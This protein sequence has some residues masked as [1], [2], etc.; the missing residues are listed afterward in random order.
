M[1]DAPGKAKSAPSASLA[2]RAQYA[3]LRGVVGALGAMPWGS[4]VRIGEGL[5]TLGYRPLGVR[6]RV[7][8]KQVAAAFPG[9]P[10]REVLRI[11]RAAFA[12]LGRSTIEAAMLGSLGRDAVLDLFEGE[13]GWG[14]VTDGMAQGKG[15]IF[16]TGHIGN[17]ELG[18]SYIAARGIPLDVIARRMAN[19]MFD[20]YLTSTR[21]RIGMH[22]VY[23]ADAV[24]R[25][26]R[27][28]REGRAVAFVADQGVLGLAST[29]VPFFG[30]PAKTPRGPAVFALKYKV[31]ML[32]AAAIRQPSGKYRMVVEPV[33]YEDTGDRDRDVD[34]TVA[35]FTRVIEG[36]VRRYP[37][38]YFWHH[39]RWKRQPPDTPPELR[40]PR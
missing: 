13:D 1:S 14:A 20:R 39:R 30:R 40:E 17:W 22:V 33:P 16:V 7:V 37:E 26:P 4:A 35:R 24:R 9:L 18:G 10:E 6:R 5:G 11:A 28:F 38:Q 19:P 32:F 8:E 15:L 27:S 34:A 12:H 23:D 25:T 2:H 36:W 31:P 29:Y 21:E 3:A